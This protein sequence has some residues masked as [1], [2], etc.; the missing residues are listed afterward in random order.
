MRG[1][2]IFL[3]ICIT[4][5]YLVAQDSDRID[6]L[7]VA[8]EWSLQRWAGPDSEQRQRLVLDRRRTAVDEHEREKV[9]VEVAARIG[10]R[11]GVIESYCTRLPREDGQLRRTEVREGWGVV[12]ANI[13]AWTRDSAVVRVTGWRGS[14]YHTG[15]GGTLLLVRTSEGWEVAEHLTSFSGA[16]IPGK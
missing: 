4:P 5:T 3:I 10:A 12:A 1:L 11:L 2:T 14:G 13:Q 7:V 8:L 16:C 6:A 9:V 15:G